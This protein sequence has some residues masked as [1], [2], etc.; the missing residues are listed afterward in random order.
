MEIPFYIH[1]FKIH[2]YLIIRI[3]KEP[4]FNSVF[5]RFR[6]WGIFVSIFINI[7][8]IE[9]WYM[10]TICFHIYISSQP[11][12]SISHITCA[13]LSTFTKT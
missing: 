8:E 5:F 7:S 12:N 6:H 1:I 4:E 13:L 9:I 2:C 10:F 11:E 3:N